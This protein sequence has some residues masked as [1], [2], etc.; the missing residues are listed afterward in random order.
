MKKEKIR[1]SNLKSWKIYVWRT[2]KLEN[3]QVYIQIYVPEKYYDTLRLLI[4]RIQEDLKIEY[5]GDVDFY[6]NRDKLPRIRKYV[7][8]FYGDFFKFESG[9]G[10][11]KGKR[12]IK[13]KL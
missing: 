11:F 4:F 3:N 13:K 7:K 1:K 2:P 6:V 10:K 5:M 9:R 12:K 8:D